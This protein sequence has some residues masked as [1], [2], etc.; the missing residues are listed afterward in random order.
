MKL[1]IYTY[2]FSQWYIFFFEKLQGL[3]KVCKF[4]DLKQE[5][6]SS[7][8]PF[9]YALGSVLLFTSIPL[10]PAIIT[11]STVQRKQEPQTLLLA[12]QPVS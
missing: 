8:L 3:R 4:Q 9:G 5:P 12:C 6:S 1:E 10:N 11:A 2:T 7:A